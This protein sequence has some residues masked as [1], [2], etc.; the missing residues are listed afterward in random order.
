M[1][2]NKKLGL[3]A[4][5]VVAGLGAIGAMSIASAHAAPQPVASMQQSTAPDAEVKDATEAKNA[6]ETKSVT[7]ASQSS[8][9]DDP[10][11]PNV[12]QTGQ[13]ESAK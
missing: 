4:I 2:I 7:E 1:N 9:A 3:L 5:P 8:K 10:N 11:G 6:P 13:N 12:E